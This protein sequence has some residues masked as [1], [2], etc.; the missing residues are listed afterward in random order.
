M[1]DPPRPLKPTTATRI[2]P[3]A[4]A[5]LVRV[6]AERL[7]AAAVRADFW[8]KERRVNI[9]S[10]GLVCWLEETRRRLGLSWQYLGKEELK[11]ENW[12][13]EIGNL[14]LGVRHQF[15]F[16]IFQFSMAGYFTYS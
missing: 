9:G 7:I 10:W 5:A 12:K 14:A 4:P 16:S 11:I 1:C 2:S 3:F 13:F 8:R 6:L 15:A